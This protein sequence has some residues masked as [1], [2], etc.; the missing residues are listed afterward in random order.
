MAHKIKE[1]YHVVDYHHIDDYRC[2]HPLACDIQDAP[3]ESLSPEEKLQREDELRVELDDLFRQ[4]GWEGDGT[5]ECIFVPPCFSKYR[6]NGDTSCITIY[7]VKQH[8]NGPSWLAIHNGFKFH[9]PEGWLTNRSQAAKEAWLMSANPQKDPR[10]HIFRYDDHMP[11]T[12]DLALV[13]LKGHLLVEEVLIEL[14][15]LVLPHSQELDN[16]RL[17]FYWRYSI[18]WRGSSEI[19]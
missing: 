7:H 19:A 9:L 8:N 11:D 3:F 2:F 15:G 5:I 13:V 17:S 16:A 10:R 12:D 6:E 4:A 1:I 14:A 18:D